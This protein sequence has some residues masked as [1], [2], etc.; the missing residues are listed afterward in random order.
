[1]AVKWWPKINSIYA[2]VKCK[3]YEG[4]YEYFLSYPSEKY[5]NFTWFP[6]VEISREGSFRIAS[7][8]CALPQNF[9]TGNQ[10]KLRYF[11]LGR[12]LVVAKKVILSLIDPDVC[13][14]IKPT[15]WDMIRHYSLINKTYSMYWMC[16]ISNS[17][18]SR[19]F[20]LGS[21]IQLRLMKK[22]FVK[23]ILF[24]YN[25]ISLVLVVRIEVRYIITLKMLIL[26]RKTNLNSAVS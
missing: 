9:H 10:V 13:S 8:D 4:L 15:V 26:D 7:G 23:K 2:R 16:C 19:Q 21:L 1:M 20:A 22:N 12:F 11:S 18:F 17:L 24:P 6:G 3:Y 25:G 14:L 5:R